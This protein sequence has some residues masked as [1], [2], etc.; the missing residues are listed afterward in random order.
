MRAE[1]V[2]KLFPLA[3]AMP[4][5][6]QYLESHNLRLEASRESVPGISGQNLPQLGEKKPCNAIGERETEERTVAGV[7]IPFCRRRGIS[8][9]LHHEM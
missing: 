9:L 8:R 6:S 2:P 7:G 4:A 3:S 1:S 5:P